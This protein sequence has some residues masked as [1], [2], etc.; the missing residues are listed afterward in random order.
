MD[1]SFDDIYAD[2]LDSAN[3]SDPGSDNSDSFNIL[4]SIENERRDQ[5]KVRAQIMQGENKVA[6]TVMVDCGASGVFAS[7]EFVEKHGLKTTPRP[8]I[9]PL[10]DACKRPMGK[11][12]KQVTINLRMANHEER[13]T[14]DV[15]P[16]GYPAILGIPWL[17][18]HNP[19]IDWARGRITFRSERCATQ[20][21]PAAPHVDAIRPPEERPP[22][23][24]E[25]EIDIFAIDTGHKRNYSAEIA[26]KHQEEARPVEEIV[27][28]EYHD[29]L[30]SV[31]S[32]K[33]ATRLPPRR[34]YD[35]AIEFKEGAQLPK[36]AG[37]Y[38]MSDAEKEDLR[39]MLDEMLAKGYIR[40]SKSP[41]A[42]P[43]FFVKKK[44]GKRRLVVDWRR[45][46][47][48]TIKDQYPLPRI[49]DIMNQLR[50]SK[51]F[52]KLDLKAGY[53][54]VRI[55]EGDEWKTA[56]RT[57]FGLFE[58]CVM[59]FGFAN[60]PACF[61]RFMSDILAPVLGTGALNYLDDTCSHAKD[62]QT[63][64][65]IN[66]QILQI[67]KDNEL[68]ANANKCEFHK[69]QIEML[70]VYVS[71]DGF[72]MDKW[73]VEAIQE[74]KEPTNVKETQA[75][76]GFC[77][78]YRRFIKDF[79]AKARCLHDLTKKD[80]AFTWG[81]REQ[82]AFQDLKDAVTSAPVLVHADPNIPY[83]LETDA[84][85]YAYG[86]V[87]SQPQADR[88][89]HPVAFLSKSMTPAERNYDI[90][91]KEMLAVVKALQHWRQYLE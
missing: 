45:I 3:Y 87:L 65:R 78:F 61:Q 38:P 85:G 90:Y 27:P 11:V 40:K 39:E 64:I 55:R 25:E 7:Q 34:P 89:L 71:K 80:M 20:C 29:F 57:C 24:T 53:N 83:T 46:N 15:A 26:A 32:E 77:N 62:L 86:A 68:F 60:A 23:M 1:I 43:C 50:G 35:F 74:W 91:D 10:R 16:V 22:A 73:K 49:D 67:F 13:I 42:S 52:T 33:K 58:F 44:D 36:P 59:H 4:A 31:F 12:D 84:S 28:K 88:R 69:D 56:F 2:L 48:I 66:R 17:R 30:D 75:F 18:Y 54:L 21:L 51:I 37:V 81:R 14:L 70:G 19:D 9:L 5:M 63:H 41:V 6:T 76:L 79:S 47:D 72:Q 8:F 82:Q